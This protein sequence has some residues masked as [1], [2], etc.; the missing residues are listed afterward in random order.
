MITR[1]LSE[2]SFIHHGHLEFLKPTLW[3]LV[4]DHIRLS[5]IGKKGWIGSLSDRALR[6]RDSSG[7]KDS[8][9]ESVDHTLGD[10]DRDTPDYFESG[11][12]LKEWSLGTTVNVRNGISKATRPTKEVSEQGTCRTP[13]FPTKS[14][15]RTLSLTMRSVVSKR[16]PTRPFSLTILGSEEDRNSFGNL[17]PKV[18][19]Y[20][21]HWY[22]ESLDYTFLNRE[23]KV[24]FLW[25]A[26]VNM[27]QEQGF[28]KV[29]NSIF[30]VKVDVPDMK[31]KVE[32]NPDMKVQVQFQ[33]GY[34][35]AVQ[36]SKVIS[37]LLFSFSPVF[38][39]L[40]LL[41]RVLKTGQE[42]GF[43]EYLSSG[44]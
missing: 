23:L 24:L 22:S 19:I 11:Q 4:W 37:L 30:Q 36:S 25:V 33:S 9:S 6:D 15:A 13:T 3:V 34:K 21:R 44:L 10:R 29:H 18:G 14:N 39:F 38:F 20:P 41:S 40:F 27:S 42:I 16:W 2:S 43:S 17:L 1:A 26:Y 12:V 31:V 32:W 7:K 5:S 35:S 8:L 28:R